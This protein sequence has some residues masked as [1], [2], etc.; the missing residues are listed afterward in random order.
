VATTLGSGGDT[1]VLKISQDAYKGNA[2]YT[3][4]VDG[5]QIGGTLTAGASHAA[6]Q[7]DTITVKGDWGAGSHKVTV[8]F[9]NDS[10][11]GSAAADRNLHVDGITFNGASLSKGSADL[12]ANGPVDF[13][14]TKATSPGPVVLK[15]VGTGGDTLVLK[16]S[17][18]A[19][20]G[21]AQYTISV[22][23][24]QIGGTL[25]AHASHTAGRDDIITVKGDW[26]AGTHKLAVKFLNDSYGGSAAADRNLHVDGITYN[27]AAVTKSTADLHSN[28][29]VFFS[30]VDQHDA[31]HASSDMLFA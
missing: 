3:I 23:G 7:D 13:G 21:D 8:K 12:G 28:G 19:Y 26:A 22:D 31:A 17:Q 14:F 11:G 20:K 30:F 15:T 10:Y 5:K 9:L 18:D 24:K 1:L 16:V 29:P 6:G 2:Q 4:S 27:G 25:T